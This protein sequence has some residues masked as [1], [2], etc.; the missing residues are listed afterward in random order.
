VTVDG[1]EN[2]PLPSSPVAYLPLRGLCSKGGGLDESVL[3]C[4]VANG[5]MLDGKIPCGTAN[6]KKNALNIANHH[7][8]LVLLLGAI[9]QHRLDLL[10]NANR[11][12][13]RVEKEPNNSTA[14]TNNG[15][16]GSQSGI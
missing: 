2:N 13:S 8:D 3:S 6:R 14:G 16:S 1:G 4:E 5:R 7:Q 15:R 10:I 12:P 11:E 9:C